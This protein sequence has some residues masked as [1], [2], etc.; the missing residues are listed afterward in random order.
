MLLVPSGIPAVY[1]AGS[2]SPRLQVSTALS[3]AGRAWGDGRWSGRRGGSG[4]ARQAA[5]VQVVSTPW[6][7][8]SKAAAHPSR[9]GGRAAVLGG[10]LFGHQPPLPTEP[11]P[12]PPRRRAK[13][14]L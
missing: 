11:A 10:A 3:A 14:A 1:A 9:L 5:A 12:Q 8:P 2:T 13:N 4:S 6:A 7:T